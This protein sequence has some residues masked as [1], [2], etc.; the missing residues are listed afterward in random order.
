MCTP[1][2]QLAEQRPFKPLVVGS[3]PTRSTIFTPVA[4]LAE[5]QAYILGVVGSSPSG[6]TNLRV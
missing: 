6:C 5:R 3:S 1:V 2:A 4:Q